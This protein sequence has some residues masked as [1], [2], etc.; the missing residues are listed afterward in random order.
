MLHLTSFVA[1][2][3]QEADATMQVRRLPHPPPP[4]PPLSPPPSHTVR[5]I[6]RPLG[7]VE[8]VVVLLILLL[9]GSVNF[10][11]IKCLYAE[12]GEQQAFFVSQGINIIYVLYGGFIVYPRL[13]PGGVG[14]KVSASL[15]LEPIAPAMR[16]PSHQQRFLA[17]G[18]LDTLGTFLTAMGAV[19][20]PGQLQ[21]LLNQSL[22]PAT[23]LTSFVFLG[24]RYSPGQLAAA[25][26]LVGGAALSVLPKLGVAVPGGTAETAAHPD[27]ETRGYAVALYWLSNVPMACS[28]VYKEARFSREPMDVTYLTQ[29][30]SIYQM[31]LGFAL[32]PLM[33]LPGVG[34]AEGQSWAEITTSFRHGLE[35]FLGRVEGCARS[36]G[37]HGGRPTV[38]LLLYVAVNF[39]FNT[40][41]LYL[42]KH[43]GA[44][45][46]SISYS[47]LL[48]LTTLLFSLPILGPFRES[49][50]PSTYLGLVVVM[51]GFSLWR[52]E[53]LRHEKSKQQLPKHPPLAEPLLVE[54]TA[55]HFP[56]PPPAPIDA[57]SLQLFDTGAPAN[58][59]P[60]R[61]PSPPHSFQERV[62]GLGRVTSAGSSTR[63]SWFSERITIART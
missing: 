18:A 16:R 36:H 38:L 51:I 28:A 46:N 50:S 12:F 33:S 8:L 1:F 29:W 45:L 42:T 43:G 31:I 4:S 22:I 25:A 14:E 2:P 27:D 35:C 17:M 26:L 10:V 41:G 24:T 20:T 13:L 57:D 21:P 61:S 37:S 63:R 60:L 39:V 15:G 40:L 3:M 44:V 7:T 5:N 54:D 11:L 53:Q 47:L 19:F 59:P 48:P 6:N 32:A 30:V 34:T 52:Y 9:S 23:M 62:I 49:A 55:R 56:R 58:S